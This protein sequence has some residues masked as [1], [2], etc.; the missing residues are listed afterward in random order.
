MKTVFTLVTLL[1]ISFAYSQETELGSR[2]MNTTECNTTIMYTL[3]NETAIIVENVERPTSGSNKNH[4]YLKSE[5]EKLTK[6]YSLL[7]DENVFNNI[8]ESVRF[9]NDG[10]FS[11]DFVNV[12]TKRKFDSENILLYITT[13]FDVECGGDQ[14]YYLI[15]DKEKAL[16]I[17]KKSADLFSEPNTFSLL[18]D[19]IKT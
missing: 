15:S 10:E 12:E 6:F 16:R 11:R 1:N 3:N 5:S 18:S 2:L 17:L 14:L 7:E 4:H 9:E 19:L 8:Y 13:M